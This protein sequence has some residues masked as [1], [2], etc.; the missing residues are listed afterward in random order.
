M[1]LRKRRRNMDHDWHKMLHEND[2]YASPYEKG[3][4][5]GLV[6]MGIGIGIIL[7]LIVEVITV[8]VTGGI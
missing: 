6:I 3:R 2:K 5:A 8:W 7:L 1:Y 4:N